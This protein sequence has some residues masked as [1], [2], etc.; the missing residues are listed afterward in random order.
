MSH[1]EEKVEMLIPVQW[2]LA[3]LAML[4][5]TQ[6]NLAQP[7]AALPILGGCLEPLETLSFHRYLAHVRVSLQLKFKWWW[8]NSPKWMTSHYH[9]HLSQPRLQPWI[10]FGNIHSLFVRGKPESQGG[11]VT[12]P[13][14]GRHTADRMSIEPH[15]ATPPP[16]PLPPRKL[17]MKDLGCCAQAFGASQKLCARSS[18]PL[19]W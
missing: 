6:G 19:L 2:E 5:V 13:R 18:L 12:C 15:L 1:F 17:R 14:S 10:P 11:P 4:E 9:A 16:D 7:T 8:Q 3:R